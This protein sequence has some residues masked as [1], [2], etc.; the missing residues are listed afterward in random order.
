MTNSIATP[1]IAIVDANDN[2]RF[3]DGGG[4]FTAA[5]IEQDYLSVLFAEDDTEKPDETPDE[6]DTEK[7]DE[8]PDEDDTEKP[9]ET[10]DESDVEKPGEAPSVGETGQKEESSNTGAAGNSGGETAVQTP[11]STQEYA[12]F[13]NKTADTILHTKEKEVVINTK[14][15]VSFNRT[16]FEAIKSRPD[17]AVTVNYIYKGKP[18]TLRIP[19]GTDVTKLMDENGFGGFRYIEKVLNTKS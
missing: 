1:V 5:G 19:A 7:P 17:V 18:Y 9:G 6:D 2:L 13:L 14:V 11:S 8:T 4:S 16:V 3:V 10:P 15:W 12:A